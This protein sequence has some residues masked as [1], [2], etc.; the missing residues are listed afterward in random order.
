M[1]AYQPYFTER[2]LKLDLDTEFMHDLTTTKGIAMQTLAK[3]RGFTL[4]E[5][6][7][8]VAIIGIIAAIAIPQYA[9]YSKRSKTTEATTALADLRIKMEQY[10]QDNRTYEDGDVDAPCAP[11][12][13]LQFFDVSC[14]SRSA[15]AFTLTATG[16]NDMAGYEYTIDQAGNKTSELA[17]GSSGNCWLTAKN[18]SC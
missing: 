11:A 9:E 13:P 12:Q 18:S 16:K 1:T 6:M 2:Q 8:T 17:D 15:T 4:T 7:I 5:V 14:E 3:Q 10:Y